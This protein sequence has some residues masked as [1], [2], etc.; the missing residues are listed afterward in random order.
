L[1]VRRARSGAGISTCPSR[2]VA[3]Q[4]CSQWS[5]IARIAWLKRLRGE[6]QSRR[7]RYWRLSE[8]I[9]KEEA[10]LAVDRLKRMEATFLK[11]AIANHHVQAG[12]LVVKISSRKAQLL[13]LD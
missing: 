12:T 7:A 11:E 10:K 4:H 13:G 8:Q 1:N 2:G 3:V 5:N 6:P 9:A